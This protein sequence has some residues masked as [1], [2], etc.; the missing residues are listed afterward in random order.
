[1]YT[2]TVRNVNDAYDRGVRL[3]MFEGQRE[4]SRN[5]DVLAL[6]GPCTITYT[7]PR[8]RVLFDPNRDANP[9]FHLMEAIWMLAGEK[10][11]EWPVKFN[12]QMAEYANEAG[13]YD[14]AYGYRWRRHFGYDQITAVVEMLKADP[15]TRRAVI[16]MY[17]ARKDTQ[18]Q[19]SRDIPC[20][21]HIYFRIREGYLDMTVCNRS[22]DAVWGAFGANA[23]HMSVLQEVVA[24]MVDRDVGKYHQFTNNLHIY[25]G[26]E[27]VQKAIQ[28]LQPSDLY[29][30]LGYRSFPLVGNASTFL[31]ECSMFLNRPDF[32][33][34]YAN[35]FFYHVCRPMYV[36]WV[37]Y[38][39]GDFDKAIS[40]ADQIEDDAWSYAC[41]MWLNR[42]QKCI[43]S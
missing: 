25:T 23:V 36:S 8:E 6:Q 5:G 19:S 34:Y 43:A 16:A 30:E 9:F 24:E 13:E 33:H 20:N 12:K 37:C 3:V 17:D 7:N 27:K 14:G 42:R 41:K 29:R 38:K 26:I 35:P 22:N 4:K 10:A 32:P 1:M 31:Q 40:W 39:E 28:N 2:L 15:T 11:A 21:T 18:D